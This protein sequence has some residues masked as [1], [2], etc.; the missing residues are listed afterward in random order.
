[1]IRSLPSLHSLLLAPPGRFAARPAVN[2]RRAMGDAYD[3][4]NANEAQM[5]SYGTS[6][7]S[8][9]D[10]NWVGNYQDS[11]AP[12]SSPSFLDQLTGNQGLMNSLSNA[13]TRAFGGN[14]YT[15]T[16]YYVPPATTSTLPTWFVPAALGVG[17][18][19]LVGRKK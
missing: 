5:A 7:A 3:G 14:T 17:V 10:P 18:L 8:A 4:L 11:P 6:D 16:S 19:M 13:V 12:S 9:L 15:P 1:M 2:V